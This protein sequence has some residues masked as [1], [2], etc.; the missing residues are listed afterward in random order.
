MIQ[1]YEPTFI[2]HIVVR[3]IHIRTLQP[4][5]DLAGTVIPKIC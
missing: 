1:N 2:D 4:I 3:I 5:F